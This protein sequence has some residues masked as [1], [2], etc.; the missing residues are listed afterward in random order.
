MSPRSILF[1]SSEERS[2]PLIQA[3]NE[4]ELDVEHCPEIFSAVERLTTRRFDVV[5]ADLEEGP[6]ARFLLK[7]CRELKLSKSAFALALARK[8]TRADATEPDA[9][10]LFTEELSPEQM[11]Y[12]LLTCDSF[13]ACL[14]I[15]LTRDTVQTANAATPLAIEQDV[16]HAS[17]VPTPAQ[18]AGTKI[19]TPAAQIDSPSPHPT[20]EAEEDP[21]ALNLTFATFDRKF[22]GAFDRASARPD[23][24]KRGYRRSRLMRNRPLWISAVVIAFF[25]LG[26]AFSPPAQLR[27]GLAG[28]RLAYNQ[29]LQSGKTWARGFGAAK[30]DKTTAVAEADFSVPLKFQEKRNPATSAPGALS[31]ASEVPPPEPRS[32]QNIATVPAH[33]VEIP[34]SLEVP[35]TGSEM[36]RSVSASLGASLLGQLE[37]VSLSEEIAEQLLLE[38]VQPVYPDRAVKAGLQG[39]VVL[40]AWIGRDGRIRDLKLVRG[41]FLLGQA[42]YKAVKQ[43]RYKPYLRNGEAVEAQTYVT[44]DFQLPRQS[45]LAPMSR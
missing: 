17:R 19:E 23:R 11:K 28:V 44:V 1:S 45:L 36:A 22:L 25:S 37:P 16:V 10:L 24:T 5:V 39:P 14:K 21:S 43:W 12:A 31:T 40:Q 20:R 18:A 15:W 7:T 6:E 2:R 30:A 4:L 3:L 34:G 42:A 27:H 38:K 26:Y 35:Q 32:D 9:D 29:A 8:N 41:S 33:H 13:L